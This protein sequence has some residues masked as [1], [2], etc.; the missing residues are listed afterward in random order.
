MLKYRH[1]T[2]YV[3]FIPCLFSDLSSRKHCICTMPDSNSLYS[4]KCCM[5]ITAIHLSLEIV[6]YL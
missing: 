2:Y 6:I 3:Y 1:L 5:K 4:N